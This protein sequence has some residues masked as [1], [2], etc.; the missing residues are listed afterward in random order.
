MTE[1]AAPT[2]ERGPRRAGEPADLDSLRRRYRHPDAGPERTFRKLDR[3]RDE[4]GASPGLALRADIGATL[5]GLPWLAAGAL[6]VGVLLAASGVLLIVIP[7][8]RV[9]SARPA[10]SSIAVASTR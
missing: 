6:A 2:R 5:P 7:V 1:L 9:R 8:R 10:G 3:R 4:P